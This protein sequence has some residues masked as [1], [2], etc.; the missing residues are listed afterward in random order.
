VAG[1]AVRADLTVILGGAKQGLLS[2]AAA[3]YTGLLVFADIGV[4]DAFPDLPEVVD[5][6]FAATMLP[7]S[8][9][10]VHKGSFGRLLV[11]AGSERYLGAAY[12]VSAAASRSGAGIVTL[13]APRWLRDVVANRLAEAT[14]LPLPDS[15]PAGAAA[16]C[17]DLIAA[18][19]PHFSAVALGPGLS[20]D[21]EV[22]ALVEEVIRAAAR[23]E[24]PIV[25][26][27]DGLNVLARQPAWPTWVEGRVVLTPHIGELRRLAPDEEL[28]TPRPWEVAQPL[29][30]QWGVTLLIKGPCTAIA[31]GGRALVHTR[32]NPALATAG[33][34][35][36]LTGIIGGL[37][38][39]G[40]PPLEAA[41]LGTWIHGEAGARAAVGVRAG[42]LLASDLLSHI[43]S[44]LALA[45]AQP[46]TS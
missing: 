38:A 8:G 3:P 14:Y 35:D 18:E 36:V 17:A 29:A 26:D 6:P 40:L 30:A 13:A 45:A 34:G 39:R 20:T 15:G 23:L 43:P 33:T 7:E 22:P 37:L 2:A 10:A 12:L 1:T 16:Q 24:K 5:A 27:A 9:P 41:A 4:V 19:L 28:A 44:A 25:V 31:S 32:P 46:P 21:G 42:G 11:V